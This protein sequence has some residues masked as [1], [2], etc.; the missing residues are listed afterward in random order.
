MSKL[1][2]DINGY[3]QPRG[4]G[5][6]LHKLLH[7][8]K[9][10]PKGTCKCEEHS[11]RMNLN[12]SDWCREN[13]ET[14]LGWLRHAAS[15]RSLPFPKM[16]VNQIITKS[17]KRS[18]KMIDLSTLFDRVYCINLKRRKDRWKQFKQ[19]IPED[20]PF[21]AIQRVD[22]ID[23]QKCKAP[24]WWNQG[25]GAWGCYKSH[26]HLIETALNK[27]F[28]SILLLED[29]ATFSDD[30]TVRVT[31]F[32]ESLPDDWGMIYFGGQHLYVNS[33][34][35]KR[36]NKNVYQPYN[37]NRTHAFALRGNMMRKVYKH[38]SSITWKKSH[39]ID[40]HLGL[41]HQKRKDPIYCP[42]SWLVGQAEGKSNISNRENPEKFFP[43]AEHIAEIDP[44]SLPFVAILGLHSS[45]SSCLAGVIYHLGIHL[46]NTLSGYY[47]SDPTKE[48][49]FEAVGLRDVCEACSP[50]PSTEY[51]LKRSDMWTKLREW[52]HQR[53]REAFRKKTIAG[54]KYPQL[55]R[56]GSQLLNIGNEGLKVIVSE[57][58]IED[59]LASLV[60]RC[61]N[62]EV[63][64]LKEHQEWLQKG[65]E[66]ILKQLPGDRKLIV[67]YYDLLDTPGKY[68]KQI[69]A[70]LE[71]K[72][73]SDQRESA[74]RWVNPDKRH[75]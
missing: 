25:G 50:F 54:G 22:A 65:K 45:G 7:L 46:G 20:W 44:P 12:G 31:E 2:K 72:P 69:I 27:G 18:E 42:A 58:P 19:Q 36:I 26:V 35:P 11:M 51:A 64:K 3:Y 16:I 56:L 21:R 40:H 15:Q 4:P 32:V 61:P 6:E 28:N 71:I 13:R 39:H 47:G 5:T 66:W 68:I 17:I 60:K 9:I 62:R 1:V 53:K 70:F 52:I 33:K 59:S 57:R 48:C 41:L 63:K 34:P 30:F 73:D 23:G 24:Q 74:L 37:I 43:D 75:I 67:P 29:D 55:C 38:V 8:I 10:K 14:I 49:G